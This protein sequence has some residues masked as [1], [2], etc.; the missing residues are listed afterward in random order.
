MELEQYRNKIINL[1][2]NEQTLRDLYLRKIALGEIQGPLTG[3]ASLD[4]PWLKYY[5][6]DYIKAEVPHMTAYEY[7]KL[8]NKN[9]LDKQAI[10][11]FE[12][13]Y[14]FKELFEFIEKVAVSLYCMGIK[15]EKKVLMM[16]P[17]MVHE[18]VL[19]YGTDIVGGAI[20]EVPVESAIEDIIGKINKLDADIF[21]VSGFLLDVV[22]EKEIYKKTGLKNIVVIGDYDKIK[23]DNRTISWDEFLERGKSEVL[24][25]IDRKSEDLLFIASTGGSTGEPKGVMLND[26]CFNVAVHQLLNSDLNYN[27]GDRWLRLW[28]LFSATAAVSNNHLPL[29]AGMNNIIRYFPLNINEFDQMVH[30]EKS[31]HLMLIPQLLDVLEKSD[32]INNNSLNYIKTVGC[33]GLAVTDEFEKRVSD[34]FDK[35]EIN[36]FLGFGWGC[37]ENSGIGSMRSNFD[38]TI[39]GTVGAPQVKATV[40]VFSPETEDELNYG[41]EGELCIK[42]NTL[43]MGYYNDDDLTSKVLKRHTDGTLWLHTGDLGHIDKNGIVTVKGRMTRTIFVFP[44]AKVYPTALENVISKIPGVADVVIGE[45]PDPEHENFGLP[46]CFII[47]NG[48]VSFDLLEENINKACEFSLASYAIPHGIYMCDEF[49]LTKVGKKDV[50]ALENMVRFDEESPKIKKATVKKSKNN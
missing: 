12:G 34:F 1:S 13:K 49:P 46:V 32:L 33:G 41:E 37:T 25:V 5:N 10:D 24:P 35:H 22:K 29:C 36:T 8:C 3:L 43:M 47:P 26:N 38:T 30:N 19:F 39:V 48:D 21:F 42:S 18:S 31:N 45:I 2:T 17:P 11:S 44:T 50:R 6:E 28:S 9:N 7:L 4:K 40:S 20:S 14:T 16:L 15:K 23:R 27:S